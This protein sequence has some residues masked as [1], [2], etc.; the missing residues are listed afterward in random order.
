MKRLALSIALF[1]FIL[2]S[3]HAGQDSIRFSKPWDAPEFVHKDNKGNEH[4]LTDYAGS[5]LVVNF[6][7]TWCPPCVKEMP[8]LQRLAEQV[9]AAGIKVLGI[10]MGED[11][12][13]TIEFAK[14]YE[15][16]FPLLLDESMSSS[17]SWLIKGLPT[18]YLINS[19]GEVVATVIGE[20][21]WDDPVI[22]EQIKTLQQN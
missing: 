10:N 12:E 18:T 3:A 13:T 9:S 7:A 1:F 2:G 14:K 15:V 4:K 11:A 20:R 6:W 22:V 16:S 5:G 19:S 8:S 21:A 17:S